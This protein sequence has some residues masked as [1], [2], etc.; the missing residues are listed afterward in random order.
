VFVLDE[1][2]HDLPVAFDAAT[3]TGRRRR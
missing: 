1:E 2:H 3:H